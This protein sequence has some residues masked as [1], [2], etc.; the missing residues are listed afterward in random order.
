MGVIMLVAF[1]RQKDAEMSETENDYDRIACRI[2]EALAAFTGNAH[3]PRRDGGDSITMTKDGFIT[4]VVRLQRLRDWVEGLAES[5][6]LGG[7]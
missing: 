1:C 4:G 2:D 5:H 6:R 7:G 3:E